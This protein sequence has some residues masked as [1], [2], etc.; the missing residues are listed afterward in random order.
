MSRQK[1]KYGR[2]HLTK[3]ENEIMCLAIESA[4]ESLM[5]FNPAPDR[6]TTKETCVAIARTERWWV[7]R[8]KLRN[9]VGRQILD[10]R[11]SAFYQGVSTSHEKFE[12]FWVGKNTFDLKAEERFTMR[13]ML[14]ELFRIYDGPRLEVR[15]K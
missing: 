5:R 15:Q 4:I 12:L 10:I 13:I 7:R 6:K 9:P 3:F 11:Y 14:M 1:I 2:T 8:L